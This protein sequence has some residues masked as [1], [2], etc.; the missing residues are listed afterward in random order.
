[1]TIPV[2]QLTKAEIV[3]LANHH[4]KAHRVDFLSHYNCFLREKP[5]ESPFYER[6]GFLDIEATGLKA[7]WD[8][9]LCY[10]IKELDG[11]ILGRHLKPKEI[12]S[13]KFDLDLVKE[14]LVDMQKFHRLVVY[15]GSNYRYDIPFCR[16]RAE[17]W[18]LD[19]PVYRSQWVTDVYDIAKQKLC[20]HRTRLETVCN[21]LGIPSKGHRLEP[22]IWQKAQ[23]G[24]PA[25][26]GFIFAHCKEDVISLEGAWKRLEKY[27]SRGKKSI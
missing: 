8:F 11:K 6:I 4:C 16:T 24:H 7:N 18:G 5:L 3:W 9:M 21:L 13:Y 27:S 10:C 26:L 19:F 17:K 25:S 14:L 12:L 15:Y 20:L 22:D 2:N 23:A 1:M